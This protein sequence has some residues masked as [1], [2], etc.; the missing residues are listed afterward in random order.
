[1]KHA[2][3]LS[4]KYWLIVFCTIIILSPIAYMISTWVGPSATYIR[5][6]AVFLIAWLALK[7]AKYFTNTQKTK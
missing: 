1:M 4:W 7:V 2:R 6:I 3:S 5:L